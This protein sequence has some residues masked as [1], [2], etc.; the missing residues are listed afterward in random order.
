M[1]KVVDP[2]RC[3]VLCCVVCLLC[4]VSSPPLPPHSGR[5]GCRIYNLPLLPPRY[6]FGAPSFCSSLRLRSRFQ[7]H[8]RLP[9]LPL[10]SPANIILSLYNKQ[11]PRAHRFHIHTHYRA[12]RCNPKHVI[13]HPHHLHRY[14]HFYHNFQW[15]KCL[16][17]NP[18]RH[19]TNLV[20]SRPTP[21]PCFQPALP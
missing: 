13:Q 2:A 20:L 12:P 9:L 6:L 19:P 3:A 8:H 14:H 21:L 4:G 18:R 11:L 5:R 16:R 17:Y 10:Y 7:S 1:R 15:A